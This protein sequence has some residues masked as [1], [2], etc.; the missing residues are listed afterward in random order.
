VGFFRSWVNLRGLSLVS[1]ALSFGG[2]FVDFSSIF[3]RFS[4]DAGRRLFF[5]FS[6][7]DLRSVLDAFRILRVLRG[8]ASIF[9][10]FSWICV[11][12]L[13][14]IFVDFRGFGSVF[15][16]RRF[17]ISKRFKDGS[18]RG[19]KYRAAVRI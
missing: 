16:L 14:S 3:R 19:G 6:R 11:D 10:D 12:F 17:W 8:F 13:S 4:V 9:V 2:F 15:D 7:R 1:W 5:P 18:Q